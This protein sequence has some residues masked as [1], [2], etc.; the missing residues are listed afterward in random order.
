MVPTHS[1]TPQMTAKP[2]VNDE[3]VADAG[4]DM[5]V[6]VNQ[7]V[8]FDGSG[9]YDPDDDIV[10]YEWDFG[11]DTGGSGETPN[12]SY[13]AIGTYTVT[14]TVTDDDGLWQQLS[15]LK[16]PLQLCT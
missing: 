10:S 4:P 9:S 12:H 13:S 8:E 14:L 11:D 6:L 7:L 5:S 15:L 3:P 1:L 16:N 2:I